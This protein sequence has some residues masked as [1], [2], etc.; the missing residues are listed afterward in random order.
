M[1][2]PQS[3]QAGT[4]EAWFM[5]YDS[6]GDPSGD[7]PIALASGTSR[8]AYKLIG[9]QEAPSP[10][11]ESES[12][13]VPGDDGSLGA[14]DFASDAPREMLMNFGLMDLTFEALLQN[15]NVDTFGTISMGLLDTDIPFIGYGALIIQGK[16]VKKAPGVSGQAAWSGWIY[17]FV[18]LRP[19]GRETASGRTA[20]NVAF[21]NPWGTTIV[22][23]NGAQAGAYARPFTAAH[24]LTLHAFRGAITSFTLAKTPTSIATTRPYSDKVAL[25]VSSINTPTPRL[26]TLSAPVVVDRAGAVFFEYE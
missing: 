7:S 15:S 19:L 10:V 22:D 3:I 1:A 17:P 23:K 18:Q 11:Q 4:Q 20:G 25:T 21:N 14:L 13:S 16:A 8:P 6:N 2:S 12:V 9:I 26:L 5:F 24:P